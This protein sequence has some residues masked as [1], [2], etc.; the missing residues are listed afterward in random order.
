MELIR[1]NRRLSYPDLVLDAA[2][3]GTPLDNSPGVLLKARS[4][5]ERVLTALVAMNYLLTKRTPRT[6]M[7]YE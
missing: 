1:S 2:G 7:L 5:F 3:R 6:A 4:P